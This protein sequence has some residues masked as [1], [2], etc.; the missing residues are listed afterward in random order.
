MSRL[1]LAIAVLTGL[2][3]LLRWLLEGGADRPGAEAVATSNGLSELSRDQLY[4]EAK[5]LGIEGRSKMSKQQLRGAIAAHGG[6][7]A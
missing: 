2:A 7:V 6:G 3:V 4:E 1:L 5:R